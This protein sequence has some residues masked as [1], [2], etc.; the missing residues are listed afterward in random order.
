VDQ[1]KYALR[2]TPR[3]PGSVWSKINKE[4]AEVMIQQGKMTDA[5][6]L[7]IEEAKKSGLW[8]KAYT[9]TESNI[10]PKDLEDA[11]RKNKKTWQNFN[12]FA[13]SYRNM[14]IGWVSSAKTA[15]TRRKRIDLVVNQSLE[16]KKI[17][18]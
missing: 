13:F 11:L 15:Q 1:E 5:G 3:K 16:N 4:K 7:K 17:L 14:Y 10:V 2:Y 8:Q 18:F 12:G 6:L 9:N